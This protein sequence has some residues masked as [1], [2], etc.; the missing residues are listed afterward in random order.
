M[1]SMEESNKSSNLYDSSS[2]AAQPLLSKP[3][4]TPSIEE[5]QPQQQSLPQSASDN[6]QFLQI[7]YNYGPRPFKDLP[8]LILFLLFSI[9]CFGFGIFSIAHKNSNFSSVS[10]FSYDPTSSSCV[11]HTISNHG[12]FLDFYGFPILSLPL[13]NL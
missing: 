10:S 3:Y 6:T 11:K 7:A 5:Y 13:M 9:C 4:P 8:F 2:S 12:S 1:A